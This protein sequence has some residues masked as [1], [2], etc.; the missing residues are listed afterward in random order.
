MMQAEQR[1]ARLAQGLRS[2]CGV[3]KLGNTRR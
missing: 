2:C 3:G 1:L